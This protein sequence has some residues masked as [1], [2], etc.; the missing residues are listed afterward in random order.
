MPEP[1]PQST[2]PPDSQRLQD[3]VQPVRELA[4]SL[5]PAVPARDGYVPDPE[6]RPTGRRTVPFTS[7]L[8]AGVVD[9]SLPHLDRVLAAVHDVAVAAFQQWVDRLAGRSS[10]LLSENESLAK[11]V[12]ERAERFGLGLYAKQGDFLRRVSMSAEKYYA[13][14][15]PT[16]AQKLSGKIIAR[17][18]D[19]DSDPKGEA[20]YPNGT[21]MSSTFGFPPLIV[22]R[23]VGEAWAVFK[24]RQ[25]AGPPSNDPAAG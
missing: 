19:D 21:R 6:A 4:V 24:A 9:A 13:R 22:A 11:F 23:T 1:N 7:D 25:T 14:G 15:E 3:L 12:N 18:V 16:A 5:V 2:L 8:D 10:P 17:S 20:A